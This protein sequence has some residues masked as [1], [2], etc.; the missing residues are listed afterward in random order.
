[1]RRGT[2]PEQVARWMGIEPVK[3]KRYERLIPAAVDVV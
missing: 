2:T 1:L 3:M